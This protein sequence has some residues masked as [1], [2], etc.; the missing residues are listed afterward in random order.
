MDLDCTGGWQFERNM[1]VDEMTMKTLHLLDKVTLIETV[2]L[3]IQQALYSPAT[4]ILNWN[5]ILPKLFIFK[6]AFL[7]FKAV[8]LYREK[9][10]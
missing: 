6:L 7:T 10:A 3:K 9:T 2:L 5:G 1:S 4:I 8:A